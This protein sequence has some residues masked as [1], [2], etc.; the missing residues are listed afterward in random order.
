M[1][2]QPG[3]RVRSKA[4]GQAPRFTGVVIAVFGKGKK[5][6]YH[7]RAPD[8]RLWHRDPPDIKM[9]TPRGKRT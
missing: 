7:V 2:L 6:Y 9:V 1:K 5:I 4:I 3:A 8:G